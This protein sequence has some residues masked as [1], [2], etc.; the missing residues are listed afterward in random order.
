MHLFSSIDW[1]FLE[2]FFGEYGKFV[3]TSLALVVGFITLAA[4]LLQYLRARILKKERD[5]ARREF[6]QSKAD[7]QKEKARVREQQLALKAK[8]EDLDIRNRLMRKAIDELKFREQKL[9]GTSKN[10]DL[11]EFVRV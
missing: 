1:G 6:E 5:A 3:T 9:K 10:S 4:A 7:L 2:A 11:R 8:E